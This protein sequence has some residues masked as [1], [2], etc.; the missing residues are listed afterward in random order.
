MATRRSALGGGAQDAWPSCCHGDPGPL[1]PSPPRPPAVHPEAPRPG[2]WPGVWPGTGGQGEGAERREGRPSSQC[3]SLSGWPVHPAV[4]LQG[5]VPGRAGLGVIGSHPRVGDP[6]VTETAGVINCLVS[7]GYGARADS[8]S[9]WGLGAAARQA[10]WPGFLQAAP[11]GAGARAGA[12][13]CDGCGG[14]RPVGERTCAD[15][16]CVR[17]RARAR[18]RGKVWR[19]TSA[20]KTRGSGRPNA[21]RATTRPLTPVPAAARPGDVPCLL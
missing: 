1:S 19:W 10:G 4:S 18:A 5:P 17:V 12:P 13:L 21:V 9:G 20:S 15:S 2:S 8:R 11:R 3:C 16:P 6:V 7:S 14:Q